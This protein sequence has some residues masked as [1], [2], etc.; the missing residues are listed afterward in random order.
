MTILSLRPV[1]S[2]RNVRVHCKAPEHDVPR[3]AVLFSATVTAASIVQPSDA[4]E[5]VDEKGMAFLNRQGEYKLSDAEWKEKL[6]PLQY[7]VLRQAGTERP[8]LS[9]LNNEKRQGVR[10]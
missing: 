4:A 10:E 5:F 2:A 1:C 9:P 6:L 7:N 3:R 8:F